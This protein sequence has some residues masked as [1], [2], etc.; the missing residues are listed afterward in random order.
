MLMLL[1]LSVMACKK[2]NTST[3]TDDIVGIWELVEYT[4]EGT[5][6]TSF[7]GQSF[8]NDFDGEG[9]DMSA[10]VEFKADGTY[11]SK[12]DFTIDLSTDLGNGQTL[13]QPYTFSDFIGFGTYEVYDDGH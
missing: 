12:G 13:D 8:S 4:Y 10:T 9:R 5:S 2:D 6:T 11:I 7:M 1:L 3:S